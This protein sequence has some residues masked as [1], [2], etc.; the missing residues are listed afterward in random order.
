MSCSRDPSFAHCDHGADEQPQ[1]R[2]DAI[3]EVKLQLDHAFARD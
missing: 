2:R 1:A 3:R